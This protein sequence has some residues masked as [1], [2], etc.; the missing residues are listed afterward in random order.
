VLSEVLRDPL[1]TTVTGLALGVPGA[2]IVMRS[3]ASLLYGVSAFDLPTIAMCGAALAGAGLLAAAWPA[4][5]ALAIDPVDALR[6][7]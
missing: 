6:N 7:R 4:R 5:R 1:A 2:F 3:A